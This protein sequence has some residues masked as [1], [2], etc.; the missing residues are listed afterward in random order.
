MK[1]ARK[2]RRFL[3]LHTPEVSPLAQID[4]GRLVET[5]PGW[6][7]TNPS[8]LEHGDGFL[9]TVRCVN[10]YFE[11]PRSLRVVLPE[12]Q[13]F[14]SVN[15]FL[16]LD[17]DLRPVKSLDRLNA[18]FRDI[19]IEDIRLFRHDGRVMGM[20]TMPGATGAQMVL[21]DFDERLKDVRIVVLQSPFDSPVEKN[22]C[23]LSVGGDL[24]CV[25]AFNPMVLFSIDLASGALSPVTDDSRR[26]RARD[27]RFWD[28]GSTPAVKLDN[29]LL[30]AAHRRRVGL[31]GRRYAYAN[32]MY[33]LSRDMA[34]P[35][36]SRYFSIGPPAIQF[37]SGMVVRGGE[38]L[39]AYGLRDRQAIVARFDRARFFDQIGLD[40]KLVA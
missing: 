24:Y 29:R 35:R 12:G 13:S 8:L 18:R 32:R 40:S 26:L 22:W 3:P 36:A 11:D 34:E 15:R 4:I 38:L 9:A 30:L 5:P 39:I 25:Y 31:P 7:P 6:F 10:Y 2:W 28:S 20:G 27:L 16:L 1:A 23:P 21:L 14:M 37:V 17:R 19:N 33:T